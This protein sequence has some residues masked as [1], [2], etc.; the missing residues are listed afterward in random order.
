MDSSVALKLWYEGSFISHRLGLT[1]TYIFM[2][3]VNVEP[4]EFCWFTMSEETEKCGTFRKNI[5]SI[6]YRDPINGL[7][8]AINDTEARMICKEAMLNRIVDCY[9]VVEKDVVEVLRLIESSKQGIYGSQPKKLTPKRRNGPPQ[10]LSLCE[11]LKESIKNK[12]PKETLLSSTKT[13]KL[14]QTKKNLKTPKKAT[15]S[16]GKPVR[17]SPRFFPLNTSSKSPTPSFIFNDIRLSDVFDSF[18]EDADF[19]CVND[20]QVLDGDYLIVEEG[21]SDQSYVPDE[22]GLSESEEGDLSDFDFIVEE[23]TVSGANDEVDEGLI[24]VEIESDDNS[25]DEIIEA[26]KTVREW[27]AIALKIVKQLQLE[28]ISGQL[29]C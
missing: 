29:S 24:E 7:K 21:L 9:I 27:N 23:D 3:I 11:T 17:S 13:T 16:S 6:F 28:A 10:P 25:D 14:N 26:R 2:R 5:D 19:A 22:E 1:Y 8:R 15:N 4:D 12:Q 20:T 18:E